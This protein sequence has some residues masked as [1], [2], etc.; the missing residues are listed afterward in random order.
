[1]PET[2]QIVPV[3]VMPAATTPA[4][5]PTSSSWNIRLVTFFRPP[6]A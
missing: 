1:M 4:R 3:L 5:K 2:E 6:S